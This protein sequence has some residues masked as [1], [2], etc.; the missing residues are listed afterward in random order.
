[1]PDDDY[2]DDDQPGLPWPAAGQPP[3]PD[4]RNRQRNRRGVA[5]AIT[6]VVAAVAGFVVVTAVRD[7]SAGPAAASGS[8]G[9]AA[10]SGGAVPSGGAG[11][12][13]PP[14]TG[15]GA[16]PTTGADQ[17]LHLEIGGKVT[18]VSATSITLGA[19]GRS[20]T[21]AVT[22]ATKVT[23]KVSGIGGVK[24][25]DL[26]SAEITG[27]DGKLTATAVQDPA[28]VSDQLGGP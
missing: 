8:P 12:L 17:T 13:L 18:A 19:R 23:G 25:G 5:L 24:V 20:V 4:P 6:T 11:N 1:M 22:P 2:E 27:T 15:G 28:S 3:S 7:V 21:A 10:P 26:A 14:G 9:T 16:I